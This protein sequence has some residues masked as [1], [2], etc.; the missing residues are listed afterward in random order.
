MTD[1]NPGGVF[2]LF[3][4]AIAGLFL[5]LSY[6]YPFHLPPWATFYNEWFFAG[7]VFLALSLVI[8]GGTLKTASPALWCITFVLL[9]GHQ[10]LISTHNPIASQLPW[11]PAAFIVIGYLAFLLGKNLS[12]TDRIAQPLGIVWVAAVLA[13][14]VAV[15]Q[16]L[17]TFAH[18]NWDLGL[19]LFLQD[20]RRAASLIGQSNHLGTI[21]VMGCW[22]VGFAWYSGARSLAW[23]IAAGICI[24]LLVYGIHLSGSRTA[25]LNLLLAP[26]L[27]LAWCWYNQQSYRLALLVAAPAAFWLAF[28]TSEWL[29]HFMSFSPEASTGPK[30][31]ALAEG[32]TLAQDAAR[33]RVW[34]M[35]LTAIADHPWLGQGYRAL[36]VT[37]LEQAPELGSFG[38]A[39]FHNAHNLV[40]EL[41][42]SY[43]LPL[44]TAL[45]AGVILPWA[46]AWR[47]CKTIPQQF[48]WL[49]CSAM[50]VH[51]M[52][53]YPLHYGYFFWLYCL[54]L[55]HLLSQPTDRE[56][57]IKRPSSMAV[58]WLGGVSLALYMPWAA[59]VKTEAL[60]TQSRSQDIAITLSSLE[61]V[62]VVTSV[63]FSNELRNLKWHLKP[64]HDAAGWPEQEMDELM[65]VASRQPTPTLLWKT[66]LAHG[67]RSHT[68]QAE[69]WAQRLCVMYG[70]ETCTQAKTAWEALNQKQPNWPTLAWGAWI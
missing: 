33:L 22:I 15:L 28:Q 48:L 61:N 56:I 3:I 19:V 41:W 31:G 4:A 51:A 11:V 5:L 12:T 68:P 44:G 55:G 65:Q 16:H 14:V 53:E 42:T 43:G 70:A 18:Q 26:L 67:F 63:L 52:L 1:K 40:L 36:A 29:S 27:V 64:V 25:V 62:D 20:G 13:A 35:A 6:S 2:V 10:W 23:R 38:N 69:W 17:G 58:V 39:I 60:Y 37:Q 49:M 66:A 45:M 54:L 59:Y 7:F 8:R 57:T 50:L 34:A 24:A 47:R 30:T 46:V 9:V 21:L 32:R